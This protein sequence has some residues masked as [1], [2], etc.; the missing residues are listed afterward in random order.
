[1]FVDF[2]SVFHPNEDWKREI[3]TD[4]SPC[5]N[6]VEYLSGRGNP[7]YQTSICPCLQHT[8]WIQKVIQKLYCLE[9][10]DS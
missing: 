4:N 3:L 1:M 6:C 10:K 2:D 5:K 8:L 7:Y 9:H